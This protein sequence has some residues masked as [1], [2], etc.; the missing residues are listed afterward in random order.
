M[1]HVFI[2]SLLLL[3]C[4]NP[5]YSIG[6]KVTSKS[7]FYKGCSGRVSGFRNGSCPFDGGQYT[8]TSVRCDNG[9]STYIEWVCAKD[10]E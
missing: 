10:L 3:G 1:K 9:Y 5:K 2:F 8:L 7:G 4:S 6:D